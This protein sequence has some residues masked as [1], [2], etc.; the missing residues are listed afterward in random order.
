MTTADII[1]RAPTGTTWRAT[2]VHD[3]RFAVWIRIRGTSR[4]DGVL[5]VHSNNL[6]LI[7]EI[8]DIN[9][10]HRLAI[11]AA[12]PVTSPNPFVG[13]ELLS[14]VAGT[15]ASGWLDKAVTG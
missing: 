6:S 7:G 10:V 5:C 13:W 4:I 2:N 14:P 11:E 12:A 1:S 15:P 3:D 9:A 8:R